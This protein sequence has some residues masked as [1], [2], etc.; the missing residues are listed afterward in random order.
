MVVIREIAFISRRGEKLPGGNLLQHFLHLSY[1][2][3]AQ[4]IH[5]VSHPL[6]RSFSPLFV[7][8][9]TRERE[10]KDARLYLWRFPSPSHSTRRRLIFWKKKEKKRCL[11]KKTPL[12][13]QS[14]VLHHIFITLFVFVKKSFTSTTQSSISVSSVGRVRSFVRSFVRSSS[15]TKRSSRRRRRRRRRRRCA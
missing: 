1:Y 5:S 4:G 15:H 10:G 11:A 8:R 14:C 2:V 7:D 9:S 3:C 13:Y 12:F 6:T